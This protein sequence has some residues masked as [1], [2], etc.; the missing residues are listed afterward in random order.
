[1]IP[2][3]YFDRA[4]QIFLSCRYGGESTPGTPGSDFLGGRIAIH[5]PVFMRRCAC[6]YTSLRRLCQRLP[7][8]GMIKYAC[9]HAPNTCVPACAQPRIHNNKPN[10]VTRISSSQPR[11][12]ATQDLRYCCNNSARAILIMTRFTLHAFC[13]GRLLKLSL[14]WSCVMYRYS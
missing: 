9:A 13:P 1:M 6:I 2:M 10:T 4:Y 7:L 12:R 5:L 8:A 11:L 14:Q 3:S